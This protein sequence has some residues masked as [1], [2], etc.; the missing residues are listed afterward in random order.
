MTERLSHTIKVLEQVSFSKDLFVKEVT[1]ALNILLPY[2]VEKLKEWI[3]NFAKTN[4][5]FNEVLLHV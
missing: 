2:E 5:E 1:K 3:V 4:T